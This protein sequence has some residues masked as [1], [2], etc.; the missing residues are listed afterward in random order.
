MSL[1]EL[2]AAVLTG[3]WDIG[4]SQARSPRLPHPVEHKLAQLASVVAPKQELR[5]LLLGL[6]EE[7]HWLS[8]PGSEPSLL[9]GRRVRSYFLPLNVAFFPFLPLGH[10]FSKCGSGKP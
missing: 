9:E 1:R 3:S 4:L 8:S 10:R 6:L 7:P 5:T 2:R